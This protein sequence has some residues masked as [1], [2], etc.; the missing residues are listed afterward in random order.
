MYLVIFLIAIN[1]FKLLIARYFPLIG[2]EA[3]YWLWSK[4]LDLSY[5]DHPPMIAYVNFLL[6]K[7][8]GNNEMAIRLGAIGI[9]L[10]IS[11]II[12]ITARELNGEKSATLSV[13]LFNLLPLFFGGGLFL[14]P[15]TLLFLF[16][17]ASFY[18]LVK[19]EKTNKQEYWYLLG[20]TIGLGFLSDYIM[21]LFPIG[22]FLYSFFFRREWLRQKE[23]YLCL[24]ITAIIFSPV[25][26]WNIA[27]NFPALQYHGER[28]SH[29]NPQNILYFIVLQSVL[30]TPFIFFEAVKKLKKLD[31]YSIFTGVVF[32][33]FALLSPFVMIGG[34]WPATAYLPTILNAEHFKKYIKYSTISFA[35]FINALAIG[36]YL[37]LYPTPSD[38]IPNSELENYV[39][40]QPPRTFIISNNLGLAALVSFHGKTKVY[41]AP[42]RHPQY[43]LWGVPPLTKGDNVLYFLLNE[44][45]LFGKLKPLFETVEI[46]T[47]KRIYTKDAD[48]PTKTQILVCKNFKGGTIP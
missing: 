22:I 31:L 25:I 4:H 10:L 9:V 42:G 11:W 13:I 30:F 5:V 17:A 23:L 24:V 19:I 38:L 34:H 41:M 32:I 43:D 46:D 18:L 48:I 36:Y 27:Y 20:V 26:F 39:K 47:H 3:Y 37:F 28:A 40:N 44:S 29:F 21:L 7:I 1:T 8:F 2:D 35:L 14:V 16:W 6:T 15:Q 45:E 12:Y 33:P